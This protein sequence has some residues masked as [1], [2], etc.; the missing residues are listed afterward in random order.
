[1][2]LNDIQRALC[3]RLLGNVDSS[4]K[5]ENRVSSHAIQSTEIQ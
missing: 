4:L 1:M 2:E 3:Y 5:I